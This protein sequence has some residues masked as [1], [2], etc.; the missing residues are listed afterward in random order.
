MQ[1]FLVLVS[2]QGKAAIKDFLLLYRIPV[3]TCCHLKGSIVAAEL[4]LSYVDDFVVV[5]VGR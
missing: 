1:M 3:L 2:W 4:H 5:V